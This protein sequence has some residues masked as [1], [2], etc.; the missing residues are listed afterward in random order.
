MTASET[1]QETT[2]TRETGDR[3]S[4]RSSI[5]L[6]LRSEVEAGIFCSAEACLIF[7]KFLRI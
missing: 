6:R 1:Y 4:I 3:E 5:G 2:V 7:G